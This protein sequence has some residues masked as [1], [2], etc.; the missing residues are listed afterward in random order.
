MTHKKAYPFILHLTAENIGGSLL[1]FYAL[2]IDPL[3]VLA[4]SNSAPP[5]MK[6]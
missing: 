6:L 3:A 1:N 4:A 5:K 2:K